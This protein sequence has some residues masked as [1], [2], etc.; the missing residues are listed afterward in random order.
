[1]VL[2]RSVRVGSIE[3]MDRGTSFEFC[4]RDVIRFS[5]LVVE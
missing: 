5:C 3:V 4:I 2:L 1:M